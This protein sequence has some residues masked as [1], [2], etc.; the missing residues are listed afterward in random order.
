MKTYNLKATTQ[1]KVNHKGK[2]DM[3]YDEV[4]IEITAEEIQKLIAENPE[5]LKEKKNEKPKDGTD[6]W[7][8]NSCGDVY[9]YTWNN[10]K[11]DNYFRDTGNLFLTV[12]E[13]LAQQAI[14]HAT[15]RVIAYIRDNELVKEFVN[16]GLNYYIY[17]GVNGLDSNDTCTIDNL[18]QLGYLI[19]KEAGIQV[20]DNNTADLKLIYGIK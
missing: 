20:I 1:I 5:I 6:Y 8:I 14:N 13:C 19:S 2:T 11:Y 18:P 3:V 16:G 17:S 15:A 12:E 10:H 9:V 7:F 4:D